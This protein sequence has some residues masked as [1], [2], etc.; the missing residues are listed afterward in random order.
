ME[1]II[2]LASAEV[3]NVKATLDNVLAMRRNWE[4]EEDMNIGK[5]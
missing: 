3:K 2:E 5:R 4:L 1:D